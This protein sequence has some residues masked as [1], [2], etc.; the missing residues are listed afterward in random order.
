MG[1]IKNKFDLVYR[2]F[3]TDGVPT[4]G[5]REPHKSEIREIGPII[6][7]A[8]ASTSLGS[9]L[10]VTKT[11]RLLL[12]ADRAYPASSVALVFAD[13]L[14]ANNDLYIK[15]GASG[16]GSWT[17]TNILHTAIAGVV[18]G[19]V[20]EQVTPLVAAAAGSAQT[21]TDKAGEANA[22][23]L[24]VAAAVVAVSPLNY[25]KQAALKGSAADIFTITTFTKNVDW[26]LGLAQSATGYV[27][28]GLDVVD[29][30]RRD[31]GQKFEA[32][33][34]PLS[35][36]APQF[37]RLYQRNA[38]NAD[39]TSHT[40]VASGTDFVLG[41]IVL[42]AACTNLRWEV[43]AAATGGAITLRWPELAA[44]TTATVPADPDLRALAG[45]VDTLLNRN[46][47]VKISSFN[48]APGSITVAAGGTGAI[49]ILFPTVK[50]AL[51]TVQLRS[52]N[53]GATLNPMAR[54]SDSNSA[55]FD[56]NPLPTA[57]L[58]QLGDVAPDGSALLVASFY[59]TGKYTGGF[60]GDFV[61]LAINVYNSSASPVTVDSIQVF[62]GG[63][64]PPMTETP[65]VIKNY[66]D[67]T[68][69][70][71]LAASVG[72]VLATP[73]Q[74]IDLWG[75]SL[76]DFNHSA[77]SVS[78]HL[79]TY[80][81][82]S[83]AVQNLGV[84]TQNAT[85]ISMRAGGSP[86]LLSLVGDEIPATVTAATVS[87]FNAANSPIT[88]ASS[89][90]NL[91]DPLAGSLGGVPGILASVRAGGPG[92]AVT[93]LSF[94]RT[95]AGAAIKISK[96]TPFL[97][98]QGEL[99]RSKYQVLVWGKNNVGG[100]GGTV[101]GNLIADMYDRQV[102]AMLPADKRFLIGT[103][104]HSNW[105]SASTVINDINAAISQR[106]SRHMVDLTSAPTTEEMATVSFTPTADDTSDMDA[107]ITA[108]IS[109]TTMTVSAVASGKIMVGK[110]LD[111]AAFG[112]IV[113]TGLGT[114]T[115]GTGTYTVSP[116]STVASQTFTL[117]GFI[118]RGMRSGAYSGG[119]GPGAP[120]GGDQ[121]HLNSIGN[122]LWALRLYRTLKQRG[123]FA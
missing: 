28:Q 15:V 74:A 26:S 51:Y 36:P 7:K 9:M 92:T 88:T 76:I 55:G 39:I 97:P 3:E 86:V 78:D 98:T 50:D 57:P 44:G 105:E 38:A 29:R 18:A 42:D 45:R 75:D 79:T 122:K 2:D 99:T 121:L 87:N 70:D 112:N 53:G 80:L 91:T 89:S 93:G 113:V 118:P 104:M 116:S 103:V 14:D 72:V 20:T 64:V 34:R 82:G 49:Q 108:A 46:A 59:A 71:G 73:A 16:S 106:F 114:G 110:Y 33:V 35:G 48:P 27:V 31:A 23:A 1:D 96:N 63:S 61:G 10:A 77:G 62:K 68:V 24:A 90:T 109:G 43:R 54:L 123:W 25:A 8:I 107:V 6:E 94:T 58:R 22:S 17:L 69:A 40:L 101:T 115:G 117:K 102:R 19:K 84:A 21:A 52:T 13:P 37:V 119:A 47:P 56:N 111:P 95:T 41:N 11:T 66:I 32:R 4:S 120:L 83:I 85:H 65:Q 5:L 12:D 67:Q 100:T 81:G 60:N 30:A